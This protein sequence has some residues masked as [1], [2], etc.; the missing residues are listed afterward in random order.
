[1]SAISGQN[2]KI[3]ELIGQTS[4]RKSKFQRQKSKREVGQRYSFIDSAH[5]YRSTAR[6]IAIKSC[7]APAIILASYW[8]ETS[9]VSVERGCLCHHVGFKVKAPS[10]MS[11]ARNRA[12]WI[13]AL[14][15][16]AVVS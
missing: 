3:I 10:A 1:M 15:L 14:Q 13:L 6:P 5:D 2:S 12:A 4:R 9:A 7:M 11:A 8:A 16:I